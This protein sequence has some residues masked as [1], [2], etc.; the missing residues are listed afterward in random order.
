M[1]HSSPGIMSS[2]FHITFNSGNSKFRLNTKWPSSH[3]STRCNCRLCIVLLAFEFFAVVF[4]VVLVWIWCAAVCCCLLCI[5]A[6]LCELLDQ[7]KENIFLF[8]ISAIFT[9]ATL[10]KLWQL[11]EV[12]LIYLWFVL[13]QQVA[14]DED[15]LLLP[16]YNN[17][18]RICNQGDLCWMPAGLPE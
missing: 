15:I 2:A 14:S 3:H 9:P 5:M 18:W 17:F 4:C 7:V 6:I 11:N 16:R 13:H 10:L 1:R 8:W 12:A